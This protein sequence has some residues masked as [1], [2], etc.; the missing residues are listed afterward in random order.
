MVCTV[1]DCL[2][3]SDVGLPGSVG[4]TVR[5]RYVVSEYNALAADAA[6]CHWV[7]PPFIGR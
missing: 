3:L 7:T 2:N 6:L 1:N 4:L 5:V